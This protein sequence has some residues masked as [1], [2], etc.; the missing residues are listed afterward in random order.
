MKIGPGISQAE[1]QAM[2]RLSASAPL[3]DRARLVDHEF[4][5]RVDGIA[6]QTGPAIQGRQ[7]D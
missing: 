4:H 6:L 2:K 7:L 1:W 5:E 3:I